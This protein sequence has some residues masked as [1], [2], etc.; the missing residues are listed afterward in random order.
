MKR[1]GQSL[2]EYGVVITLVAGVC[3][4]VLTVLG[5]NLAGTLQGM[6][7]IWMGSPDAPVLTGGTSPALGA[8]GG[9]DGSTFTAWTPA[10]YPVDIR[11]AIET[12]GGSGTTSQLANTLT[13]YAAQLLE[14]GAI[15]PD[16]HDALIN[17][18]NAGHKLSDTL[19]V[20]EG[21]VAQS[22]G[23]GQTLAALL[24]ENHRDEM[25]VFRSGF[26]MDALI[27][28]GD[29]NHT[30]EEAASRLDSIYRRT[31]ENFHTGQYDTFEAY[32][33]EQAQNF[34]P[35]NAFEAYYL[36][37]QEAG[38]LSDPRVRDLVSFLAG[39]IHTISKT[40]AKDSTENVAS[41]NSDTVVQAVETT[42]SNSQVICTTGNG[43]NSGETVCTPQSGA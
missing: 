30:V 12:A 17:L 36:L 41:E 14:E 22:G 4:V 23:S 26:M 39:D 40:I 32:M 6:T 1:A 7:A 34:Q 33:Q 43:D 2:T 31:Y 24:G 9:G 27:Y 42:R 29:T 18:S 28:E 13:A 16:Q 8:P 5:N 3:I 11:A 15:T 37:A 10:N 25:E 19:G 21:F 38:A 20:L 35:I